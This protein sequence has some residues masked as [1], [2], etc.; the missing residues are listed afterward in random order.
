[1]K[2]KVYIIWSGD[3]NIAKRVKE[4]LKKEDYYCIIG[5]NSDNNSIYT[6]VEDTILNQIKTCNQAIVIFQNRNDGMVSNNVF[7]ELG[8]AQALYG[9]KKIHCVKGAGS[10]INMPSD[11]GNAFIEPLE[12]KTDNDF[13][14]N[15]VSFFLSRQKL[16]IDEN[17]MALINNR[18]FLAD[19][20][21]TYQSGQGASCSDY[22]LAQYILFYTL[23]ATLFQDEYDVLKELQQFKKISGNE[24]STEL[25]LAILIGIS[26]LN[27]QINLMSNDNAVYITRNCFVK[28]YRS[29]GNLY[30]TLGEEAFD[31]WAKMMLAENI[32]YVCSLYIDGPNITVADRDL[33][34]ELIKDYSDKCIETIKLLESISNSSNDRSGILALYKSY[35][36]RHLFDIEKDNEKRLEY[37]IKSKENQELLLRMFDDISIDSDIYDFFK[38]EYLLNL[39]AYWLENKHITPEDNFEFGIDIEEIRAFIDEHTENKSKAYLRKIIGLYVK[40][41][42]QNDNLPKPAYCTDSVNT[43]R[44]HTEEQIDFDKRINEIIHNSIKKYDD[45]FTAL[46]LEY[47]KTDDDLKNFYIRYVYECEIIQ[48]VIDQASDFQIA[49]LYLILEDMKNART[50]ECISDEDS[51]FHH[52]LFSI[53]HQEQFFEWYLLQAKSIQ[54]FL[55]GFW[56]TIGY[57]TNYYYELMNIHDEIYVAVKDRNKDFALTA[58]KKHFSVL[59]IELLGSM[60]KTE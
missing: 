60:F 24:F 10:A 55:N 26:Y 58:M 21:K 12:D 48:Q 16:S 5:G 36:F 14:D 37:L 38:M 19:K 11:F 42:K 9:I 33:C 1:M 15:I 54:N 6:S 22:E 29:C 8:Y 32:A 49:E 34:T 35:V 25:H 39:E 13:A 28:Y 45:D 51:K 52:A 53:V 3:T 57:Q 59:L 20:I 50:L 2:D 23:A 31:L 40:L 7:Y 27:V 30:D 44:P 43:F 17:K 4:K 18:A 56:Q 41:K 47:V 46:L